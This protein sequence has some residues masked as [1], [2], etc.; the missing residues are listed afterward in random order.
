[1]D[2]QQGKNILNYIKSNTAP[3]ET[4]TLQ[5]YE[6]SNKDEAEKNDI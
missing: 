4:V 2:K 1:M 6:D 3:P 5:Q